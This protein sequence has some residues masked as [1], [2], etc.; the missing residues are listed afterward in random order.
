MVRGMSRIGLS[1]LFGIVFLVTLTSWMKGCRVVGAMR[2]ATR[3][4]GDERAP[5]GVVCSFPLIL[6][7]TS[8]HLDRIILFMGLYLDVVRHTP[9]CHFTIIL[10]GFLL[11]LWSQVTWQWPRKSAPAKLTL[12]SSMGN[13]TPEAMRANCSFEQSLM[14]ADRYDYKVISTEYD[15]CSDVF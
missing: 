2:Q 3:L 7:E 13:C 14:W 6:L 12:P 5:R 11:F 9:A 1:L 4:N 10:P 15:R 8:L